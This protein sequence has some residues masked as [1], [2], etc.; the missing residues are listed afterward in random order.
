MAEINAVLHTNNQSHLGYLN[1]LIYPLA[2][3]QISQLTQTSTT[4]YVQTGDYNSTLPVMPFYNVHYG[5]NN[6]DYATY[7]YNLVTGWGSI[8]AYN[9]TMYLL[10]VNYSGKNFALSGVENT[11]NL[12]GLDVT[13]YLY[14]SSTGSYST[15]N[16]MFNASI[17]QNMFVADA[18]GAPVYW[19]QNV[20]Y[21]SGSQGTGWAMNYTGWVV[22]PFYGLYPTQAIYEYNF[23]LGKIVN[24]PHQFKIKTWLTN[25]SVLNRQTMNFEVN[26]QVLQIPVPGA[27]FIIGSQNY[28]YFWQGKYY[29]NGPY[30]NNKHTGGLD[31]QFG[32]VGGPSD[33]LGNFTSPTSGN[34]TAYIEPVGTNGYIPAST[35]TYNLNFSV[36]ETGELSNNLNWTRT[37]SGSW[38]LSI[39]NGSQTQGVLSYINQSYK[40]SAVTFTETGLPSGMMWYVNITGQSSSGPIAASTY[41]IWLANGTYDYNTGTQDRSYTSPGGSF[42]VAGA[43]VAESI[44][45]SLV[46]YAVTFSESGLPSGATWYVNTSAGQSGPLSGASYSVSLPNGT[47]TYSVSASDKTYLPSYTGSFTVSG[48]SVT[49]S[50]LFTETFTV[51]FNQTGLPSGTEWWI[52]VTGQLSRSSTGATITA[53]L[54]NGTYTYTVSTVNKEYRGNGGTFTVNGSSISETAGFAVVTYAIT[55]TETGLSSGTNWS[56][57]LAGLT[58]HSTSATI[59]FSESN[60]TYNYTASNITDYFTPSY[61]GTLSVSGS[62]QSQSIAYQHY[63]YIAGTVT[64]LNATLTI[65]GN[66][67]TATNGNFNIT[68]KAGTYALVASSPGYTAHYA[69]FTLSAGQ[70]YKLTIALHIKSAVS[71]TPAKSSSPPYLYIG[72]GAVAVI[73]LVAAAI[74]VSKNKR[75]GKH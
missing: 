70:T 37:G 10:P 40:A 36:D 46:T 24:I 35:S 56:V 11:L 4:G 68:V 26:S 25:T 73:M 66:P 65:N 60:G 34:M 45:F 42:N 71:T 55:F 15:V 21:I 62:S 72:I 69:N 5:R 3:R 59:T 16:T 54:P 32:L 52:N 20:I 74:I 47:Y 63:S 30:P 75:S 43:P 44:T 41:M 9:L 31:P 57:T 12:S 61:S 28:S 13:S 48:S 64:P 39:Q 22:Y 7:G 23:P 33:G 51:T 27:S 53:S 50:V 29:Y 38:N 19:I 2:N 6:V 58:K 14:N 67:V 8:D 49:Q 1:P 17:Q 18:L